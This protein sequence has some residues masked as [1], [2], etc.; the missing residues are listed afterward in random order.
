MKIKLT[1]QWEQ[2]PYFEE[3][4]TNSW[5]AKWGCIGLR[6][7]YILVIRKRGSI[8]FREVRWIG[9]ASFGNV[10]MLNGPKRM[11]S[12]LAKQDAEKVAVELLRD[13][14]DGIK[15]LMD[16]YGIGEDD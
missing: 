4:T 12:R 13:F 3:G 8:R 1:R 10:H 14:R 16:K 7:T 15:V 6:C 2:I 5:D 9:T 11:S